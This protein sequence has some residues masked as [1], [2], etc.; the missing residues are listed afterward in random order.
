MRADRFTALIDANVL[1]GALTRNVVLSLADAGFYRAR[2]SADILDEMERAIARML[3]TKGDPDSSGR[4]RRHRA[5]V[6]RA[7]PEGAV[8][9]FEALT[10]ELDL[11]D[12]ND[13]HVL[14]A[15]IKVGAQVIVT[16]NAKDFPDQTLEPYGIERR[17]ADGFI[18]DAI[19]LDPAGA[20][21]ALRHM[22]RRLKRPDID[23]PTL[24]LKL[25]AVGLVETANLLLGDIGNLE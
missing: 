4:S 12:P 22:R 3:E 14:A 6:E 17:S 13:R 16:E 11:P 24:I 15:A 1:A 18:A 7:F 9:G 25:E 19:D 2:W 21:E 8:E 5:A 23:P 20:V 10:A